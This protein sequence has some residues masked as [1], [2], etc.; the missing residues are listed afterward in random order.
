MA[1][2]IKIL[3]SPSCILDEQHKHNVI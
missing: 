2:N 1:N 3:R